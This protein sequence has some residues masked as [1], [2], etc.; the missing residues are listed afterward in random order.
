MQ[1]SRRIGFRVRSY[2][3]FVTSSSARR[4]IHSLLLLKESGGIRHGIAVQRNHIDQF[5][6]AVAFQDLGAEAL[7]LLFEGSGIPV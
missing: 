2:F 6:S 5:L 7:R 1:K 4:H 3:V